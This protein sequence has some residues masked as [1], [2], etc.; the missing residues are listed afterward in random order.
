MIKTLK[1]W[2]VQMLTGANVATI[3]L[4]LLSGYSDRL[5]PVDHPLLSTTGMTFPFFLAADM[6]FLVLWLILKWSRAWLPVA[7]LLLA[8]SPIRTYIPLHRASDPPQDALKIVSYNVCGY[9][10][11]YKYENGFETVMEYLRQQR[12]DII[13]TQEEIDNRNRNTF[14][15]YG[16]TWAYNDTLTLSENKKF[17]NVLGIHT[18][19]PIIRRERIPYPTAVNNGSAAWWLKVGKDTL[20]VVNNHFES[21]HLDKNDRAQYKHILKGELRRDS[22]PAES[23]L[24]LVKLSEANALRAPQVRQ[25]CRYVQDHPGYP[26]V[27]CGDFNDSPIS[28]SRYAFSQLLTDCYAETGRGIGLSYNQKGFFF[29]IDHIFCSRDI[30]SYN[31]KIDNKIDASDHYPLVCWVEIGGNP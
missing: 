3:L 4:L 15:E 30:R 6:L 16:K 29:R 7:G 28:Y 2:A 10:G 17:I 22:I 9:G 12:P 1:K 13:C 26:M 25:V 27:V 20:I 31:C 8:Y 23:Q 19:F 24:I 21:C 5:N 14:Q 18:R 11:N